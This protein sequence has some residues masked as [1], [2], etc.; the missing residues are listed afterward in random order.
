MIITADTCRR[1]NPVNNSSIV[2]QFAHGLRVAFGS[3][4]NEALVHL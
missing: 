1:R 4:C 3:R 2:D